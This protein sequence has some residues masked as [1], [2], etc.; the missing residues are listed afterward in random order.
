VPWADVELEGPFR[1][2]EVTN[3]LHPPWSLFFLSGG[4]RVVPSIELV[5]GPIRI[6]NMLVAGVLIPA[7]LIGALAVYPLLERRHL[8]D[9]VEHHELAH[10]LDVPLRAGVIAALTA[11]TLVLTLAATVDVI[12]YWL[13]AP[14]EGVIWAMRIALIVL[15]VL[16]TVLAVQASRRRV[17]QLAPESPRR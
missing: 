10:A 1:P 16:A 7:V 2:A 13:R 12:S 3:T 6:T 14:V 5:L 4:L 17:R 15:P 8:G 11:I 9:E